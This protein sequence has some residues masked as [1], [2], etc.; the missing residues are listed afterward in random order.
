MSKRSTSGEE[1]ENK[2]EHTKQTHTGGGCH[3]VD[4]KFV[5]KYLN[6]TLNETIVLLIVWNTLD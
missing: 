2:K 3:K 5:K 4:V 6:N 1:R